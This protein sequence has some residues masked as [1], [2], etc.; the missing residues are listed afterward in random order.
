MIRYA[1]ICDR[2]HD[3]EAWFRD[4]AAFDE[5]A[6]EGLVLCPR[7]QSAVVEKQIMSPGV[8]RSDRASATPMPVARTSET[9]PETPSEF[10]SASPPEPTSLALVDDQARELRALMTAWR[11]HVTKTADYV[12]PRFAQEAR[13]IHDGEVES[14]SIYGEATLEEAKALAEDGISALP[15]PIIPGERN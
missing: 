14:R 1:L 8:A 10:P 9:A 3:F 12:G 11:Q 6:A 13:R 5:Q 15:L 4:S 2:Q 7:C